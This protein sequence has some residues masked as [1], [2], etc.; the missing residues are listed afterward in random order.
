MFL[1]NENIYLEISK[2]NKQCLCAQE[3]RFNL[4]NLTHG[5]PRL[6]LICRLY[7]YICI[8]HL[9]PLILNTN[10]NSHRLKKGV[11]IYVRIY[12]Q[13]KKYRGKKLSSSEERAVARKAEGLGFDS[14][15]STTLASIFFI[16]YI[17]SV[18][19]RGVQGGLGKNYFLE[20]NNCFSKM[21]TF[22]L[23]ISKKNKSCLC[24][25]VF[26]F[27]LLN[28]THSH[29]RLALICLCIYIFVCH[30]QGL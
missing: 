6:A 23:E 10:L 27:N 1:E 5:H 30:I 19:C 2:K 14:R 21:R 22:D 24:A 8:L 18:G 20:N 17:S 11:Y 29:P 28:L 26:R 3:F 13:I 7:S 25:Q 12:R 9:E 15:F 4:L 16:V